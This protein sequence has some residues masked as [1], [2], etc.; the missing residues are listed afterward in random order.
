MTA[1]ER[2]ITK[3]IQD[4]VFSDSSQDPQYVATR[5][6]VRFGRPGDPIEAPEPFSRT[7]KS[8]LI[9]PG[10][11]FHRLV[12]SSRWNNKDYPPLIDQDLVVVA[13]YL[14]L[15]GLPLAHLPS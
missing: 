2:L 11:R 15:R 14:R 3:V 10:Y 5:L 8:H 6:S 13:D 7:A 9:V 4:V 1:I 12:G